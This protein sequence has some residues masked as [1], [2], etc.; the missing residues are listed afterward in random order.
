MDGISVTS[1]LGAVSSR[2]SSVGEAVVSSLSNLIDAGMLTQRSAAHHL[3]RSQT[4]I[5]LNPHDFIPQ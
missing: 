1:K 2:D 5:Q 4:L 3:N